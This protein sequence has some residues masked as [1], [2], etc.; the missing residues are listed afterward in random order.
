MTKDAVSHLSGEKQKSLTRKLLR[1]ASELGRYL[2]R[3]NFSNN[4]NKSD[5][6][7]SS[8]FLELLKN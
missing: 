7:A 1:K 5:S 2:L 8:S 4:A 3:A 6:S